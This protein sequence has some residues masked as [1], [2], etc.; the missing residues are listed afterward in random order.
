MP[1][2]A[3]TAVRSLNLLARPEEVEEWSANAGTTGQ[4]KIPTVGKFLQNLDR[5]KKGTPGPDPYASGRETL[6]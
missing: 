1:P 3:T 6:S 5:D 2:E 4:N